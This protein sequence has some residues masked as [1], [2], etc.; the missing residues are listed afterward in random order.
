MNL[1]TESD[2]LAGKEDTLIDGVM[3]VPDLCL[4]ASIVRD[5]ATQKHQG[6]SRISV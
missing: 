3:E 5:N 4:Y 1:L 6:T 2:G